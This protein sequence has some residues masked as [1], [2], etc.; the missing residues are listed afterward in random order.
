M[1]HDNE[2]TRYDDFTNVPGDGPGSENHPQVGEQERI[3]SLSSTISRPS[4]LD[5]Y[6]EYVRQRMEE[7]C[8]N[9][10]GILEEIKAKGYTG[11]ITTL[12]LFY[13]TAMA[14]RDWQSHRSIRNGSRLAGSSGLAAKKNGFM[15]LSWFS[16]ILG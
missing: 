10:R 14:Y 12:R 15:L 4:K 3:P 9:T 7:G 2:K 6:K 8:L 13:E 5:P 11:G 16:G 1:I